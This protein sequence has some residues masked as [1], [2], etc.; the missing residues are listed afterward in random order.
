MTPSVASVAAELLA[1]HREP[2]VH[3]PRYL[4]GH[5]A[6]P[7]GHVV[8]RLAL[9]R[10]PH[11]WS[12]ELP[13]A[14]REE[15][16]T[17]ALEFVRQVCLWDRASHYQ[18]LCVPRSAG[19]DEIRENYHLLIALIHPDRQEPGQPAWPTGSAQR[20]NQAYAT[21]SDARARAEY[22]AALRPGSEG[23]A[24]RPRETPQV[25]RHRR[26]RPAASAASLARR[27]MI[28]AGVIATLF[29]VQTWWVGG[30]APE[31][32]L[33][34][35]ALPSSARW[36]GTA[37]DAPR[38]IGQG[39]VA[40]APPME[41]IQE[42]KRLAAL[43]SWVPIP[44][45]ARAAA[46]ATP[47]APEPA[48]AVPVAASAPSP[49]PTPVATPL[50][51][52][53]TLSPVRGE[54][55]QA[56]RSP[57]AQESPQAAVPRPAPPPPMA[58]PPLRLAQAG[59]TPAPLG[60]STP[61]RDQVEG[62]VA[63][64]VGF[65]DAGDSERLVGLVDADS[66]GWWQGMRMRNAYADFFGATRTRKLR[67]ERLAW[68]NNGTVA[69]ARGEATVMAEYADGRSRLE[70]RVP[71]ELDIALRGGAAR[72]TRLVLFPGT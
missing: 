40:T 68:R 13:R 31:H 8:L 66:L 51:A 72:I 35:R 15:V 45:E 21:L 55:P 24:P 9:G 50:R 60:D 18:L 38:F 19:R 6:L 52:A 2:V 48:P 63:L 37:Q 7:A 26:L 30:L 3:R 27:A 53:S 36:P 57:A 47:A 23:F 33:L 44:A 41:P 39:P 32:S 49:I 59:P 70:R 67:M 46:P 28:V 20:A 69:E 58:E 5:Q 16:R 10:F 54:P 17:A 25:S 22:D 42:P 62:V 11:G 29:V 12:R 14:E 43:T 61:S 71:V 4:H 65:Y 1:F 56:S 64:L 34:E